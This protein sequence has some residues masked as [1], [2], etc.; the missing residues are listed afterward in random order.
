[1]S[2]QYKGRLGFR[3]YGEQ[4]GSPRE[5]G[6]VHMTHIVHLVRCR[7]D[8]LACHRFKRAGLRSLGDKARTRCPPAMQ[9]RRGTLSRVRA[10][11]VRH[12]VVLGLVPRLWARRLR[13]EMQRHEDVCAGICRVLPGLLML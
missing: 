1:M 9:P 2:C 7:W 10:L 8:P 13:V 12:W 3:D 11:L 6:G 4:A 5:K